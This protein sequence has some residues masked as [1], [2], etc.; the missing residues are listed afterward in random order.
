[1][2]HNDVVLCA[3][4]DPLS[5]A[6]PDGF[7]LTVS[8][9]LLQAELDAGSETVRRSA[10]AFFTGRLAEVIG[11]ARKL[12]TPVLPLSSGEATATQIQRLLGV[13]GR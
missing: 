9:G 11:W 7:R 8:D 10:E 12:G 13:A 1:M 3:V 2:R 5:H 6:L 4:T